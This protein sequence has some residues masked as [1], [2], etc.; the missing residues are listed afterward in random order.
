[1]QLDLQ[2]EVN[3]VVPFEYGY[4][5]LF[6]IES[7]D[8]AMQHYYQDVEKHP[9]YTILCLFHISSPYIMFTFIPEFNF[10]FLNSILKRRSE[11]K[12]IWSLIKSA[13]YEALNINWRKQYSSAW[14]P[15]FRKYANDGSVIDS[16]IC[17]FRLDFP[18]D[19][20]VYFSHLSEYTSPPQVFL[21]M[22]ERMLIRFGIKPKIH[23]SY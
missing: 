15:I 4:L 6:G 10:S 20:L 19:C 5:H 17:S 13:S 2:R 14:E 9:E 18:I 16:V 11:K 1:M 3:I 23:S 22:Q 7:K 21:P 8:Y 12:Y